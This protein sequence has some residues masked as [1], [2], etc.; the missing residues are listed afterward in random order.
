MKTQCLWIAMLAGCAT[1]P[2]I[3]QS[4]Q[5][6]YAEAVQPRYAP[7]VQPRHDEPIQPTPTSA[8]GGDQRQ[9]SARLPGLPAAWRWQV[10]GDSPVVRGG[11]GRG[12]QLRQVACAGSQCRM[13]ENTAGDMVVRAE[14]VFRPVPAGRTLQ[15]Q[16]YD[17]R[18]RPV[19][20][21]WQKGV[22]ADGKFWD[23]LSTYKLPAGD[24]QVR[25][26]L[27]H[28]DAIFAAVKFRVARAAPARTDTRADGAAA[29]GPAR[30]G[31]IEAARRNQNCW[32]TTVYSSDWT[33]R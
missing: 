16:V 2:V 32:S 3:A 4:V 12:M 14:A 19:G 17:Q 10:L 1:Q 20:A 23:D 28:S 22:F 25:Y 30:Q 24:Y 15:A 21:S 11:V 26:T 29:P 13:F 6:R 33:C 18:M 31:A 7:A 27:P 5:P 9:A 8:P